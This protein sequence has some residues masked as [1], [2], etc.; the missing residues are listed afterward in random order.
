[1]LTDAG[2]YLG[3]CVLGGTAVTGASCGTPDLLRGDPSQ[4][5][6]VGGVCTYVTSSNLSCTPSCNVTSG[7]AGCPAG[8]TCQPYFEGGDQFTACL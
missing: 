7:D 2:Y 3:F 1:V 5:C 4:L 8:T 6:V